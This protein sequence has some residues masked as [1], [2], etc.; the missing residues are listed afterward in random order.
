MNPWIILLFVMLFTLSTGFFYVLLGLLSNSK[1][2]FKYSPVFH[3]GPWLSSRVQTLGQRLEVLLSPIAADSLQDTS[4]QASKLRRELIRAGLRGRYAVAFYLSSKLILAVSIPILFYGIKLFTAPD[5]SGFVQISL[6]SS[7]SL[8]G[9]FIPNMIV[10][11]F[12]EDR[13]RKLRNQFPDALDLIRICI[14]AGLGLDAAILRVGEEFKK[15]CPPL[16]QEFHL[17]SLELRAGSSRNEAL[18]NFAARTGVPE[19][20]TFASILNQSDRF[21][22]GI[23]KAIQVHAD[24]VRHNRK[25]RAEEAAAKISTKLLFPLI[26]CIFPA[27]LLVLLGPAAISILQNLKGVT[28]N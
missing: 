1:F 13:Q 17:I 26:F 25:L 22:T 12:K 23:A 28:V 15:V 14:E 6:L 16:H 7:S 21:G 20:A 24:D 8:F 9:F 2:S 27:L 11:G 10:R 4:W 3:P 19:I 18:K 5:L